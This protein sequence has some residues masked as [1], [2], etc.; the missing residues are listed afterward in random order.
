MLKLR[1]RVG[2]RT[3]EGQLTTEARHIHDRPEPLRTEHRQ[4][5]HD[6]GHRAKEVGFHH[7]AQLGVRRLF[8][9][10]DDAVARVVDQDID[11]PEATDRGIDGRPGVVGAIDIELEGKHPVGGLGNQPLEP[12]DIAGCHDDVVAAR[13]SMTGIGV[14]EA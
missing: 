2:A 10:A 12:A 6:H 4:S 7:S 9:R 11:P 3:S 14:T 5:G 8:Q 1:R 13:Q